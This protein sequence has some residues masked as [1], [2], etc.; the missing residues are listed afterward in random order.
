[1][2]VEPE[3]LRKRKG[4]GGKKRKHL[5]KSAL[6]GEDPYPHPLALAGFPKKGRGKERRKRK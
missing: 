6:V 2:L 4:K 3:V 1:L 5:K